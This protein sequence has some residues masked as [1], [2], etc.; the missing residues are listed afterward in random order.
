MP[1]KDAR[2]AKT[3]EALIAVLR[4]RKRLL[5]KSGPNTRSHMDVLLLAC[6]HD[7]RADVLSLC[8]PASPPLL[9]MWAKEALGKD[10]DYAA[11]CLGD[12]FGAVPAKMW[13]PLRVM[14]LLEE[15]MVH[16]PRTLSALISAVKEDDANAVALV[17]THQILDKIAAV[18]ETEETLA[19][20]C[21]LNEA[22]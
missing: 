11:R 10:V 3:F 16:W 6:E 19:L 14:G 9:L 18:G 22:Y 21:A 2:A 12:M 7:T 15:M 5:R 20:M 4:V 8:N 17:E 1:V 13:S